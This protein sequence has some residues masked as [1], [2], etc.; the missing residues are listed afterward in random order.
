MFALKYKNNIYF[1]DL[2]EKK[3]EVSHDSMILHTQVVI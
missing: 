3:L 2:K 1:S